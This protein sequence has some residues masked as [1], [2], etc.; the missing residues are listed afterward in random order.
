MNVQ[1]VLPT[2]TRVDKPDVAS[3]LEERGGSWLVEGKI[4]RF[5]MWYCA[6][7]S[8]AAEEEAS[9]VPKLGLESPERTPA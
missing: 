9:K 4:P 5:Q 3:K 1:D 6:R 2:E 8:W 7:W